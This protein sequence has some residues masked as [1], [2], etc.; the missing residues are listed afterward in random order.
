MIE[1]RR[2]DT[3]SDASLSPASLHG[4]LQHL[5]RRLRLAMG[6]VTSLAIC[7]ALL[8]ILLVTRGAASSPAQDLVVRDD[9]GN[10]RIRSDL[11]GGAAVL[12]FLDDKGHPRAWIGVSGN[13]GAVGLSDSP[14]GSRDEPHV[15]LGSTERGLVVRDDKASVELRIGADHAPVLRMRDANEAASWLV[16]ADAAVGLYEYRKIVAAPP[17]GD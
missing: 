3:A 16:R 10:V 8:A 9:A 15:L 5:E 1:P 7:L 11:H 17:A 4:R 12:E 14:R 2:D 13:R 6:L